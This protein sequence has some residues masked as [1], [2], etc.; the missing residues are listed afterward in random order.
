MKRKSPN[1]DL[2]GSNLSTPNSKKN[3]DALL[4]LSSNNPFRISPLS[5]PEKN[6]NFEKTPLKRS[7]NSAVNRSFEEPEPMQ[8]KEIYK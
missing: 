3:I 7:T 4:N 2:K 5:T 6:L 8:I 1:T